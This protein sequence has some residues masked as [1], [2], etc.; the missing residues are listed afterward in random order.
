M[1]SVDLLLILFSGS[2]DF[3]YFTEV[4][5]SCSGEILQLFKFQ[6]LRL[7]QI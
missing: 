6:L 1:F 3:D 7:A 5:V 2:S 4:Q